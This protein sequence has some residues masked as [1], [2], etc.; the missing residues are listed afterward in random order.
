M[1]EDNKYQQ[2]SAAILVIGDEILSGR[3]RD[4]N[5][6]FVSKKL[7]EIG[8]KLSEI[9]VVPDSKSEI[10]SSINFVRAKYRYIFTSGGIGPTHDDITADSIAEAFNIGISVRDDAKRILATNYPNGE[11]DLND[12]RLRMARIPDGATLIDNP[13]SKAPGFIVSNV[14]VMAGVPKIFE[15]MFNSIVPSLNGGPPLLSVTV[16]LIRVESEIASSLK[17]LAEQFPEVSIGSY[18]F[19]EKGIF[20]TNVVVRH[21]ESKLLKKLEK[22]LDKFK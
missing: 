8:I 9:R 3:T 19:N 7:T 14:Y 15:A 22:L 21:T 2:P 17:E 1:L 20:G 6:H 12:S 4:L 10:V 18:P 5:S 16:K 11:K 13:I